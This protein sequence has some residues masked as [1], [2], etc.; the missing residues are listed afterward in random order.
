MHLKQE[1]QPTHWAEVRG[2]RGVPRSS[3][4]GL[5]KWRPSSPRV[6]ADSLVLDQSLLT[7]CSL[8][9]SCL[10]VIVLSYCH[11]FV[12]SYCHRFVLSYCHRLVLS[13]C[14]RLVLSYCHRLVLP[15]RRRLVLSYC[16]R[17]VLS[18]CR[19][20]VLSYC[21]RLVS[22]SLATTLGLKQSVCCVK[23]PIII[24]ITFSYSTLHG[25]TNSNDE[26]PGAVQLPWEYVAGKNAL[27]Y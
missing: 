24:R 8:V 9:L 27:A 22:I 23:S 7:L 18:Y 4:Q 17:L 12:L 3:K 20:V 14:H 16:H 19:R 2:A 25:T 21:H 13:Y 26:V 11:R 6:T 5:Q 10:I 1:C 15:Y